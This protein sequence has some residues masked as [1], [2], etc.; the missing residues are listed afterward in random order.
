MKNSGLNKR[1]KKELNIGISLVLLAGLVGAYLG[2]W[3][4]EMVGV[5]YWKERYLFIVMIFL[6][7]QLVALGT[8][9]E[10]YRK[11]EKAMFSMGIIVIGIGVFLLMIFTFK[12]IQK[13]NESYLSSLLYKPK[14]LN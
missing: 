11:Y 12:D 3:G 14:I 4:G 8:F 5:Y 2:G 10:K 1:E 13:Q 6:G 7:W 9:W